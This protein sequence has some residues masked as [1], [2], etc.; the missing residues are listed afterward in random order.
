MRCRLLHLTVTVAALVLMSSTLGAQG[1]LTYEKPDG[2][3]AAPP[4]SSMRVAQF[5]LPRADGDSEDGEAVIYYFQGAGGSVQSNLDRWTDQMLQPGGRSS[6][7]VA[8]TEEL[9]VNGLTVTRLD[10]SGTY[11]AEVMPGQTTDR[12][13]KP[14]Y[15]L[16]AAVIETPTGP[17]FLKVTG[18]RKTMAQWEDSIAAF[19]GSMQYE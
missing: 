11:V 6:R 17:F 1:A 8:A 4:S 12:Y 14:D 13:N 2:W 3:T 16:V 19:V 5:T 18:P 15:R 9:T 7:A 10:V